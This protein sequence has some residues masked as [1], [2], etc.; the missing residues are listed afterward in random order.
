MLSVNAMHNY[1]GTQPGSK[2]PMP[3][4]VLHV[5]V[6]P[7]ARRASLVE[8]PDGSWRACVRA[9]PMDGKANAELVAMLAEHFGCPKSSVSIVSGAG[10]RFKRIRVESRI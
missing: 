8:Q 6:K 10:G 7:N 9:S 1:T 2:P 3:V 5:N 4:R